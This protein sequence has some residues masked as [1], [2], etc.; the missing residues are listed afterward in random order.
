LQFKDSLLGKSEVCNALKHVSDSA[1]NR[2]VRDLV[3][4]HCLSR[5]HRSFAG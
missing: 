5:V 1:K 4:L 2:Q 3:F